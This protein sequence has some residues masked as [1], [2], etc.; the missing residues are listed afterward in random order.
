MSI[1]NNSEKNY[2]IIRAD[3]ESVPDKQSD[4]EQHMIDEFGYKDLHP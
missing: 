4:L 3:N 1:D 2:F